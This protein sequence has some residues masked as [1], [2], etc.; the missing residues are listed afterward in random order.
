VELSPKGHRLLST[1]SKMHRDWLTQITD[2]M[3]R[4]KLKKFIKA[5]E[6]I[7]NLLGE[8]REL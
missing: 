5:M 8:K 6:T 4:I 3:A 1:L 2:S 7:D